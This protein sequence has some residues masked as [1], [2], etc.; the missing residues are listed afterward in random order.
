VAQKPNGPKDV[1]RLHGSVSKTVPGSNTS[2]PTQKTIKIVG[3]S[4]DHMFEGEG[5]V[6]FTEKELRKRLLIEAPPF[7]DKIVKVQSQCV[8]VMFSQE[9]RSALTAVSTH[10][11]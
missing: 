4:G 3:G 5:D 6:F 1:E 7:I 2:Q 10:R 9:N 11:D 8:R